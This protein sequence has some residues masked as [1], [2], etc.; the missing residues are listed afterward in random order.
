VIRILQITFLGLLFSLY[1]SKTAAQHQR[2]QLP[3]FL[4][5]HTYF[6]ASISYIGNHFSNLQMEKGY[7]AESVHIPH[8]GVRLM[9]YGYRFNK[10][11]SGQLSYMRPVLWVKYRNINGDQDSHSVPTNVAG[12][13]LKSQVPV[14]GD[15]SIYGEAGLGI[16]TRSG[17]SF[18]NIPVIKN[19]NY[20]TFLFSGGLG[21]RLTNKLN[22][23]AGAGW[24]PANAKV[25]QPATIFVSGGLTY[26]VHKVSEAKVVKNKNSG[27]VFPANLFQV[28]Y[29]SNILGYGVN[30]FFSNKIFPIFWGGDVEVEKGI[31]LHYQRNIFHGRKFFSLDWGAGISYWKS[32]IQKEGFCTISIFPLFRFTVLHL[33]KADL[34][35]NYSVAGPTFISKIKI[36]N[37]ETGK[38]FTFQDFMGMGINAGKLRKINAEIR[39]AHYSN[40]DLFPDNNG[41]K[42]PLSFN[43]GRTF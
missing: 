2:T 6:E 5:N 11:L 39:I 7:T 20:F 25:N 35:F 4:S 10:Y 27:F 40:G 22:I 41:V 1:S 24:S 28:G 38:K 12:I 43:I 14:K 17:F 32:K 21:Y 33:K 42:V 36:D 8:I 15:L 37:I 34:Y 23:V 16:I 29:T 19:A 31:S 9:L 26:N 13:T 18:N 3:F 30:N